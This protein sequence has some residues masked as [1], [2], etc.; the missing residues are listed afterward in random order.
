[1]AARLADKHF[2][3]RWILDKRESEALRFGDHRLAGIAAGLAADQRH[4]RFFA[5]VSK[6]D[7][8]IVMRDDKGGMAHA[9]FYL[10]SLQHELEAPARGLDLGIS[11]LL[12][13][14][15]LLLRQ[16][17]LHFFE[18]EMTLQRQVEHA[19]DDKGDD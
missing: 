2:E 12:L 6:P 19:D 5:M 15:L 13:H 4:R 10:L 3:Q 11:F 1:V 14:L 9:F 7:H 17:H 8:T 16:A 18:K